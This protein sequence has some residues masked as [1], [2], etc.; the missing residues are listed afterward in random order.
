MGG[1]YSNC[2]NSKHLEA[3]VGKS[4]VTTAMLALTLMTK[5]KALWV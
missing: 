2:S 5:G 3:F 1:T 4:S